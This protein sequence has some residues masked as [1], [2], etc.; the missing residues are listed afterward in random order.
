MGNCRV[1]GVRMDGR[2]DGN[3]TYTTG[4]KDI[5]GVAGQLDTASL[6]T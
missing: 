4:R 6:R 1:C 5:Y 2:E 3:D